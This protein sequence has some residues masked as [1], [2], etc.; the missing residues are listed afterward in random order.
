MKSPLLDVALGW[1]R[2][3]SPVACRPVVHGTMGCGHLLLY[4]S[5]A[6]GHL[7]RV[8]RQSR[9][10]LIIWVM[11]KWSWGCAQISRHL[12]YSRGKPQK[13]SARRPYDEGAV[14]PVIA[15]NGVPFLQMRSVGSHST[16][17]REKEGNKE[18]TGIVAC[19]DELNS[20]PIQNNDFYL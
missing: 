1:V 17:G 12:P 2:L 19:R 16:S 4:G 20:S 8:S 13:T 7:P 3:Q 11:M 15:S 5:L 6:K 10:S 14:R 18:R 9:R